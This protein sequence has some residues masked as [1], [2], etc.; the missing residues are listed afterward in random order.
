M[1]ITDKEVILVKKG[2][3]GRK[4]SRKTPVRMIYGVVYSNS[5]QEFVL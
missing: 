4:V 1:L 3:L 2:F 5:S